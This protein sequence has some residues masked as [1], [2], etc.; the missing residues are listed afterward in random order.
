MAIF[1]IGDLHLS[2]GRDKPMDIFGPDWANHTEKI[3]E[4]WESVVGDDDLVIIPG[5]ISWAM[6]LTEA[7][8]DLQWLAALKGTKLLVRGNHD[9]WWSS[10]GKVRSMLPPSIHALQND[11]FAWGK[12]TICGTRG[13]LCPGEEGFDNEKDQKLYLREVQRLQFS[14]ESTGGRQDLKIIAALHF[15]PFNRKGQPSAFTA[16]LEQF[17]V[18]ICVYGHIHDQGREYIFQGRRNGVDYRFVASDGV[19][20]TPLK[21]A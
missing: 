9:Y 8:P 19:D 11:H 2:H 10:I 4:G 12:W 5:D 13:W 17:A 14:L 20:F 3:R 21:L 16:L 18:R 15:P 1:A 7:L 6:Q